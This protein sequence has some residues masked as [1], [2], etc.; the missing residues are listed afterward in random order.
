MPPL[1]T[2][3]LLLCAP[4]TF[5]LVRANPTMFGAAKE[6]KL[7]HLQPHRTCEMIAAVRQLGVPW[8]SASCHPRFR[9]YRETSSTQHPPALDP[10]EVNLD[11]VVAGIQLY[12][13]F[14]AS[15]NRTLLDALPNGTAITFYSED[16][17]PSDDLPTN[18]QS[19]DDTAAEMAS[20]HFADGA[21]NDDYLGAFP[22]R[23]H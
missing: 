21:D 12:D 14:D 7:Q 22:Q 17:V 3:R 8:V 13:V 19:D 16:A 1:L 4:W 9:K 2:A 18:T 10:A 20:H 15:P 5:T 23:Q 6:Y 11:A